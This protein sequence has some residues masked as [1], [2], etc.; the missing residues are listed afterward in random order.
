MSR[1]RRSASQLQRRTPAMSGSGRAVVW[2]ACRVLQ[3]RSPS[4]VRRRRFQPA[5]MSGSHHMCCQRLPC[6]ELA[7]T[8]PQRLTGIQST[9]QQAPVCSANNR[10]LCRLLAALSLASRWRGS[11]MDRTR[12]PGRLQQAE[13]MAPAQYA[14]VH[15]QQP[16]RPYQSPDSLRLGTRSRTRR[17]HCA[18]QRRVVSAE[19]MAAVQGGPTTARA[20]CST[21]SLAKR[22]RSF[23]THPA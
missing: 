20:R 2:L 3:A 1:R 6:P 7:A 21:A 22:R 15:I 13:L 8:Q 16:C 5:C 18:P 4:S 11:A 12:S 19:T 9:L 14:Q 10:T 17:L 23:T